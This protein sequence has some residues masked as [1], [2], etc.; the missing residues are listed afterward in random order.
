[1]DQIEHLLETLWVIPH[2]AA[3]AFA[4]VLALPVG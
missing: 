3:L 1:M 2:V 4:Y